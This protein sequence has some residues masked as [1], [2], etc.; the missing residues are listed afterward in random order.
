M[1]FNKT[2]EAQATKQLWLKAL[3]SDEFKQGPGFLHNETGDTYCCLGVL[4]TVAG[5]ALGL[6]WREE[7]R[8]EQGGGDLSLYTNQIPTLLSFGLTKGDC[9][10]L[11][12]LN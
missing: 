5:R 4:C 1:P 9:G 7:L 6:D 2:P 3:R 11:A 12:D 10:Y 8:N